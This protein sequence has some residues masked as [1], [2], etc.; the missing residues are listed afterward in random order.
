MMILNYT[1][2]LSGI[3]RGGFPWKID[4]V[5]FAP[6]EDGASPPDDALVKACHA[7]MRTEDGKKVPVE[8]LRTYDLHEGLAAAFR[9]VSSTPTHN[10]SEN[11]L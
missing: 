11:V 6:L 5:E 7:A 10:E 9:A 1:V 3:R 2:P 4:K 8:T